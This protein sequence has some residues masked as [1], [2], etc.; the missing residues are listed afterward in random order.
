MGFVSILLRREI[1]ENE[2]SRNRNMDLSKRHSALVHMV[3]RG[4]TIA[5]ML[6]MLFSFFSVVRVNSRDVK[7]SPSGPKKYYLALGDSAAFGFQPNFDFDEGYVDDFFK[8]LKNHGVVG[9][10]NLGCFGESSTTFIKNGCPVPFLRK[11]FYSNSQLATA[12]DYLHQHAGQVSPVT[13][14]IGANDLVL[15]FQ[16][17]GCTISQNFQADLQKLDAN[18]TQTTLPQLRAA[19][20]VNGRLTGDLMV[21]GFYDPYQNLCPNTIP[22][23]QTINQHLVRDVNGFGILVDIF[24]AFGGPKIPNNHLCS[25]TWMC[26]LLQDYHPTD[27]GYKIIA[28]AFENA[29]GY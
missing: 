12:L 28:K 16:R 25:Y 11:H 15:D 18:L 7:L 27:E 23:F 17:V 2:P 10:D 14:D 1:M 13:L 22:Y 4:V 5:L 6:F 20:T 29:A 3:K 19:L 24:A 21:L 26:T 8:D 9:M